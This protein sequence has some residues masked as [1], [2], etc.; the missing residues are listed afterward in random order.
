MS[1]D[2][3]STD[4]V[5]RLTRRR[6]AAL[7]CGIGLLATGGWLVRP[8]PVTASAGWEPRASLPEARGEMKA[9]ALD[10]HVYVPGGLYG[11]GS[12]TDRVDVYDPVADAW[13]TVAPLP[14]GLNHHATAATADTLYVVG[15][16]ESFGDSPGTFGF[17]YDPETDTWSEIA[18]LPDG[19]W[20]HE[21]VV[22]EDQVYV[23]GGVP[24]DDDEIDTLRYDPTADEWSRGAPIPTRREHVAAAV[25]DGEAIVVAGRWE[26][27]LTDR[28]DAYDPAADSWSELP[29][30]PTARSGFGATVVDGRLHAVG[31]ED[32]QTIGGWTS[33]AHEVYDPDSNRWSRDAALPLAVH[34]NTVV[35]VDGDVVVVGGAWRQG[36]WSITSW[37][38]RT[39]V[40]DRP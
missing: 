22:I 29:S 28:V 10:G 19:R 12:S 31:G 3:A 14:V 8:P 37:S 11:F 6:V 24:R 13:S 32:P 20:G 5:P 38:D 17:A 15:G 40:Y 16:N 30:V 2:R 34:G 36:L 27:S 33:A 18:P 9:T 1:T 7:G 35:A 26:G 21:A 25:V 39:F 4:S 23:L